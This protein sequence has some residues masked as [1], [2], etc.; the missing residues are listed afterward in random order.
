MG[1]FV[2]C[3]INMILMRKRKTVDT[4]YSSLGII[5]S[6]TA[7]ILAFYNASLRYEGGWMIYI[8]LALPFIATKRDP[9]KG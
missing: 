4:F 7:L 8:V 6:V 2:I 9:V 3:L 1:F 5:F